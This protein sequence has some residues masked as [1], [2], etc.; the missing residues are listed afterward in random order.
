M[1]EIRIAKLLAEKRQSEAKRGEVHVYSPEARREREKIDDAIK[2]AQGKSRERTI[3][4]WDILYD[5]I[6]IEKRLSLPKRLLEGVQAD[7][8][9]NAQD[10]PSAYGHQAFSTHY[11]VVYRGGFWRLVD[12][13]RLPC[14]RSGLSTILSLPDAAKDELLYKLTHF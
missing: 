7:I 14:R 10:F 8:D 13:R 11:R 1:K 12:V 9:R 6:D 5:L 3:E 4:A 2:I